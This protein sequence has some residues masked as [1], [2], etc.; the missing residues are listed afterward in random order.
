[1]TE[2]P[3]EPSEEPSKK[4]KSEPSSAW[5]SLEPIVHWIGKLAW[6][7]AIISG[8]LSILWGVTRILSWRPFGM[9][10]HIATGIATIIFAIVIIRPRFSNKCGENDWDYLLNDVLKLGNL[11]FPW[12]FVWGIILA[13]LSWYFYWSAFIWVPA[14]ILVFAGP[15]PYQWTEE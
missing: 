13:F 8:A 5:D 1:M 9:I 14:F 6:I 4:P 7:F 10:W 12:M 3:S 11:R 2:E 15:K